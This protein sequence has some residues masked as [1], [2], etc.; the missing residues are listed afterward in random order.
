VIDY[1]G[2][3]L[4]D[5]EEKSREREVAKMSRAFKVLA[6]KSKA[7]APVILAVQ[8]N[9]DNKTKDGKYRTPVMGDLRES[10]AIESDADMVVLP[11]WEGKPPATGRHPAELI[12]AKYRGGHPS[13]V[14]VD[15][16]PEYLTFSDPLEDDDP[17]E[18]LEWVPT[19]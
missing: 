14:R 6:H 2:L 5:V 16:E 13:N 12:I 8:L 19:A 17:Q 4:P 10:G 9:R 11:W 7:N 1:L 3:V 18:D 15:W